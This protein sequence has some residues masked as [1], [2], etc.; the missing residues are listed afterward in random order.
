M[1]R[2]NGAGRFLVGVTLLHVVTY[3]VVGIIASIAFD[4][5][6]LFEQPVIRDYMREFGSVA[7]FAGP[8]VQVVRGIIIAAVLLPFRQVLAGRLGWLWLWLLLIGIG[9]LSTSAAAPSSIEGL[10]YTRVPLWYHAIGL[11][12]M[13][14]QTLAF[15]VL[16]SLYARFPHGVLAALPPVFERI[17]RALVAASLAFVGY[18]V[19]SVI[20]ALVAGVGV[21]AEQNLSLEV[22][23]LFIVPFLAN[24][25]I[26]FIANRG[27]CSPGRR[28]VAGLA[29]Y[30]VGAAAIL[31]YQAVVSGGVGP[32]Y[33][34]AAPMLPAVIVWLLVPRQQVTTPGRPTLDDVVSAPTQN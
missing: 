6:T 22:Q 30:A 34:L 3:L 2:R 24:G 26:A 7:L 16:A 33:A 18:A 28:L 25:A 5:A 11:P 9:I 23:G 4:Y 29:S 1:E 12:E 32:L 13:L 17:M 21:D 27:V 19:V 8:M 10:V 14:V 31:V 20:F 15:S